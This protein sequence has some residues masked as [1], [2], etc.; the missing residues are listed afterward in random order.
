MTPHPPTATTRPLVFK[1]LGVGA[2]SFPQSAEKSVSPELREL[3]GRMLKLASGLTRKQ[4]RTS[5]VCV[6][7]RGQSPIYTSRLI[8]PIGSSDLENITAGSC[9]R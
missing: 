6:V 7:P 4:K 9:Y 5:S 1:S 3:I 2:F 8:H